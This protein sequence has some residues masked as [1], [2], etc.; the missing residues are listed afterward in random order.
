MLMRLF[1]LGA[2][3]LES[4][5]EKQKSGMQDPWE[6]SLRGEGRGEREEHVTGRLEPD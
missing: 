6:T 3:G 2:G 5:G 1:T 4:S